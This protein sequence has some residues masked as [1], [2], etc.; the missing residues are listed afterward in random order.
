M[1]MKLI[2]MLTVSIFLLSCAEP[3]FRYEPCVEGIKTI[4]YKDYSQGE[5]VRDYVVRKVH[6]KYD[7]EERPTDITY[8]D[9][10]QGTVVEDWAVLVKQLSYS[11]DKVTIVTFDRLQGEPHLDYIVAREVIKF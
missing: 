9:F 7:D 2:R 8:Q 5:P 11:E 4:E 6:C 1:L 10:L 3:A